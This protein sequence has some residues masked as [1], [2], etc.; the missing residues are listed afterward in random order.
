MLFALTA[1]L[2]YAACLFDMH[3]APAPAW[4][5]AGL[6]AELVEHSRGFEINARLLGIAKD[7]DERS[8]RLMALEG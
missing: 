1:V 8:A 2:A 3:M 4:Q 6:L 5:P 7:I